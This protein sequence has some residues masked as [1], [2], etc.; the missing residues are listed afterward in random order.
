MV[1][2]TVLLPHTIPI[3]LALQSVAALQRCALAMALFSWILRIG[4]DH[5]QSCFG[6]LVH[7]HSAVD[8]PE[9]WV[10]HG[11]SMFIYYSYEHHMNIRWTN[12]IGTSYEHHMNIIWTSYEHHMNTAMTMTK[13]SVTKIARSRGWR[14][15]MQLMSEWT[16]HGSETLRPSKNLQLTKAMGRWFP[17][18]NGDRTPNTTTTTN[19]GFTT[20]LD[21]PQLPIAPFNLE[22]IVMTGP[23]VGTISGGTCQPWI[24]PSG[25]WLRGYHD[26]SIFSP[27]WGWADPR[28]HHLENIEERHRKHHGKSVE[29][30]DRPSWRKGN[31]TGV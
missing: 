30:G 22:L 29:K 3:L 28:L 15:R 26:R 21:E 20:S 1:S 2:S 25:P 5:G 4:R 16:H 13:H 23:E 17:Y 19:N 11:L 18:R 14:R 10:Y 7:S 12:I 8:G 24:N 9:I 6:Q 27:F 31:E